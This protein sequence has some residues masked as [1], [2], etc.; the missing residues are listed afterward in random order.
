M[1]QYLISEAVLFRS[2]NVRHAVATTGE[3]RTRENKLEVLALPL[4]G[5]GLLIVGQGNAMPS[6]SELSSDLSSSGAVGLPR[7]EGVVA[8]DAFNTYHCRDRPVK[9][10]K[11]IHYATDR[12]Y[13]GR[14][15]S[16]G[17]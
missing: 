8:K 1:I 12:F 16:V 13:S 4:K 7:K 10:T 2:P 11:E 14:C 15:F 3:F 6:A 9:I 17:P 5:A